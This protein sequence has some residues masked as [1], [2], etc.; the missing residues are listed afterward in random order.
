MSDCER[1]RALI[2]DSVHGRLEPHD[3]SLVA[4][5]LAQCPSC[6]TLHDAVDRQRA[7]VAAFAPRS[8]PPRDLRAAVLGE[9]R[10]HR[11]RTW[12]RPALGGALAATLVL[13][14]AFALALGVAWPARAPSP[15]QALLREAVDD[16]IRVVLRQ[17]AGP[18]APHDLEA[19][20]TLM[21]KVLDYRVPRPAAGDGAFRLAGGRPSYVMERPVACFYYQS[22]SA[23]ASLFVLPL[24]RLGDAAR[25]FAES[26]TVAQR[27]GRQMVFWKRAGFAY[28]VVS[29]A[30]T[31]AIMA[32]AAALRRA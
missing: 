14:V 25:S 10:R 29:E 19:V 23:Y 18:S 17:R 5:H 8:M 28:F 24:D 11:R 27:D 7:A 12:L 26:P 32:L 1:V 21:G 3:Q 13:A 20:H 2:E 4:S 9:L 6:T 15:F 16:H 30:P 22:P 31:D